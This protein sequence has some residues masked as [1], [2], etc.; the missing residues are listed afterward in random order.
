MGVRG[1][2]VVDAVTRAGHST[3]RGR[4]GHTQFGG[5][6]EAVVDEERVPLLAE[7][8]HRLV[9]ATRGGAGDLGLGA[10]DPL[11][12][13]V[14]LLGEQ[15]HQLD[16]YPCRFTFAQHHPRLVMGHAHSHLAAGGV[17]QRVLGIPRHVTRGKEE[18]A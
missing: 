3:K 14:E 15:L 4:S 10:L 13:G 6:D 8:R 1:G 18:R 7:Q 11:D 5:G 17:V 12:L 16:L 2:I 9:E